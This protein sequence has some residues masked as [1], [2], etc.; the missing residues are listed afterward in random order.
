MYLLRAGMTLGRSLPSLDYDRSRRA[1]L[2]GESGNHP[3]VEDWTR[4]IA[5]GTSRNWCRARGPW[6]RQ[7]ENFGRKRMRI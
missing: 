3:V 5:P 6:H 7:F 4:S 2:N 1:K